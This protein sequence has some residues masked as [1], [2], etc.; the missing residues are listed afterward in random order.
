MAGFLNFV[1]TVIHTGKPYIK[2]LL[3][4]TAMAEVYAA[5]Q[6]GRKRFNPLVTLSSRACEDL[7]WWCLLLASPPPRPLRVAAGKV[8]LW[9]QRNPH[10]EVLRDLGWQEGLVVI[11]S[12]DASGDIGW[13]VCCNNHWSQGRWS[14]GELPKSINWKELKAYRYAL[15]WLRDLLRGKLLFLRMDNTCAVHYVNAGTG[16]PPPFQCV[17]PRGPPLRVSLGWASSVF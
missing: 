12:T 11:L 2:S 15:L 7:T 1:A 17:L 9:H 4:G 5:W 13:G 10:A 16:L 14:E 3:Q 8:F 6:N